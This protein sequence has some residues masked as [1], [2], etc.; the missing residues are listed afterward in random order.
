MAE[1]RNVWEDLLARH[2]HAITTA[3]R[4]LHHPLAWHFRP[5]AGAVVAGRARVAVH[6]R[7]GWGVALGVLS[8]FLFEA[9]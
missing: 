9:F 2:N 1:A 3:F 7:A 8:Q 4:E 6:H 5:G